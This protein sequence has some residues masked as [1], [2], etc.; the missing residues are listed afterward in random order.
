ISVGS[1]NRPEIPGQ[2]G[3]GVRAGSVERVRDQFL[4]TQV[5]GENSKAGYWE[6]KAAALSRMENVM[7]ETSDNGLAKSMDLFW[8]SLQDL[9][10]NPTNTGGRSVVVQSGN[11]FADTFNYLTN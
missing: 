1:R 7:N 2:L 11:A 4:D 3:T 9:A 5:R 8:N 10:T 6:A